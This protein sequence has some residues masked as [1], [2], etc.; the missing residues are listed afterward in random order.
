MCNPYAN[1]IRFR[2]LDFQDI[3]DDAYGVYGIW[4]RRR[5]IYVGQAKSQ[6]IGK[7]LE[8]HWNRPKNSK[9]KMWIEAKA[10]DLRVSYKTIPSKDRIDNYERY[11][12]HK[13]QPLANSIRYLA[14]A[15]FVSCE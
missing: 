15:V 2:L 6:P 13:F 5:C 1:Q 14:D 4:Y 8:Q 12:I 7:R 3:P 9:L 10:R 11:Y